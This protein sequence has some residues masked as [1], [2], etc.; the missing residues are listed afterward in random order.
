MPRDCRA[1]ISFAEDM[2]RDARAGISFAGVRSFLEM[3]SSFGSMGE[4]DNNSS[5]YISTSTTLVN[6]LR[7]RRRAQRSMCYESRGSH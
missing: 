6:Q 4:V 5:W 2:P 7:T 1:G 3:S